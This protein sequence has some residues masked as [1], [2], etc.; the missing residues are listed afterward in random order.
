MISDNKN[1]P[2]FFFTLCQTDSTPIWLAF[3]V[4]S[5]GVGGGH[6]TPLGFFWGNTAPL[7]GGGILDFIFLDYW[8]FKD[9]HRWSLTIF[10][11]TM[12]LTPTTAPSFYAQDRR[13]LVAVSK[14]CWLE[15]NADGYYCTLCRRHYNTGEWVSSPMD[16]VQRLDEKAERHHVSVAH[17]RATI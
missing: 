15:A 8:G 5:R 16:N 10:S 17:R 12:S 9:H 2:F 11:N 4:F 7:E 13:F 14:Y 1:N 6:F 3:R